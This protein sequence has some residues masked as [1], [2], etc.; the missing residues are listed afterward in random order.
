VN[1]ISA[2]LSNLQT[3]NTVSY[4]VYYDGIDSTVFDNVYAEQ[5]NTQWCAAA[6]IEMIGRLYGVNVSQ[7]ELAKNHCG[8][9]MYGNAY[10]CPATIE[11]ISSNLNF[12]RS[13]RC[14]QTLC[15]K[16]SLEKGQPNA[17]RVIC[18]LQRGNPIMI[19]HAVPNSNVGHAVL[20][21]GAEWSCQN[22]K[23]LIHKL[24]L[25]DPWPSRENKL[26]N[27]RIVVNAP[28]NFVNTIYAH[29]YISVSA[30]EN[31]AWNQNFTNNPFKQY[32]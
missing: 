22:G 26:S 6:C 8:I 25:R 14:A 29:W 2:L 15:I 13:N 7:E 12:C 31:V 9:D 21:T 4:P 5:R 11:V 27:G 3:F 17:N 32:W 18:E 20:I 30:R 16:P 24:I 19:G 23:H 10:N 28:R 1:I